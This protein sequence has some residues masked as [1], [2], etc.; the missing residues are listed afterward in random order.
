M[1]ASYRWKPGV[2]T[3]VDAQAAGEELERIRV[4]HNGRLD[5]ENLLQ[6]AEKKASPLHDH[7]EWNDRTA[8]HQYRLEQAGYLI[9]SIEVIIPPK[10]PDEEPSAVRAFVN[11][12][13]DEDRS[14]TSVSHAMADPDLRAQVIA[15]AWKELEA[16]RQRHAELTEFARVFTSIDQARGA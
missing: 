11:V 3:R 8:A 5:Q 13:R 6:E 16:W 4:R 1:S 9:R 15:Q 14:Y 2:V 10:R 7:F 12:V